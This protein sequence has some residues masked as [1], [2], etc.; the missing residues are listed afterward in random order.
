MSRKRVID[1]DSGRKINL[2]DDKAKQLRKTKLNDLQQKIKIMK[3][4]PSLK[5]HT[6]N[7][8]E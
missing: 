1:R 7:T 6:C 4:Y 8:I 3:T 5:I 2:F